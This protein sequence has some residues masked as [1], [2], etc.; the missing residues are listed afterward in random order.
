MVKEPIDQPPDDVIDELMREPDPGRN[1]K[2]QGPA[3][4]LPDRTVIAWR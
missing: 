1:R 2:D 3:L 4:F